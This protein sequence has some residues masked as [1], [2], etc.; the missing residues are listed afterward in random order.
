MV[1]PL[2]FVLSLTAIVI[3]TAFNSVE[4]IEKVQNWSGAPAGYTGSPGD[5]HICTECH[6]GAAPLA[7]TGIISSDIPAEGYMAGQ[8]YT[9]TVTLNNPGTTRFGFEL[10]P[11]KTDGSLVGQW[12]GSTADVVTIF[13]KFATHRRSSSAGQDTKTWTMQWTAPTTAGAGD[14]TFYGAFNISNANGNELGDIIWKSSETFSENPQSGLN[15]ARKL[16]YAASVTANQVLR[17]QW[18]NILSQAA[19][20]YL[21][22]LNGREVVSWKNQNQGT[23][24]WEALLPELQ[25][26]IYLLTVDSGQKHSSQKL[27]VR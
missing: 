4:N 17:I 10:S 23:E 5:K 8:V 22:D 21:F 25:P 26:G 14:V 20:I 3:G 19:D 9:I 15:M 27:I 1:K 24:L 18:E 2:L 6:F 13:N 7:K 12:A 16:N 11:Q